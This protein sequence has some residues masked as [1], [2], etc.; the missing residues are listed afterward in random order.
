[1]AKIGGFAIMAIIVAC[2]TVAIGSAI[3]MALVGKTD[4]V[5]QDM[6]LGTDA[7]TGFN[8]TV[9]TIYSAWP[10]LGIV[11]LSLIGSAAIAAIM[12]FR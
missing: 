11:V 10:L 4:A 3:G 12:I 5:V 6:E 2:I 8:S 1:M 7:E 9:S